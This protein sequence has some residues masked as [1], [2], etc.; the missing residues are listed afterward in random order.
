ME[1]I[2]KYRAKDGMTFDSAKECKE[3]EANIAND[4][5]VMFDYRGEKTTEP[6]EAIGIYIGNELSARTLLEKFRIAGSPCEG[7][8]EDSTGAYCWND[9]SER[10]EWVD[11]VNLPVINSLINAVYGGRT[12]D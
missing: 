12:N 9:M 7:L 10:Y 6:D 11:D 1:L 3:Y 2:M 8:D 4:D 5:Y